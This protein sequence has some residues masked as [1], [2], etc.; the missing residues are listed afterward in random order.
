MLS[1]EALVSVDGRKDTPCTLPWTMIFTAEQ[2]TLIIF[3]E[4]YEKDS[5]LHGKPRTSTH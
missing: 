1:S 4:H 5:G 3:L 2:I